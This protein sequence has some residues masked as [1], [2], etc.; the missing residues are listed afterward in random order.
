MRLIAHRG[1]MK[2]PNH[3]VENSKLQIM[4]ALEHGFDVEV[5]V[6]NIRG[7]WYLGHDMPMYQTDIVFLSEPRLWIHAKNLEALYELSKTKFNYFWHQQDDF[8]LTSHGY[9][10]TY[11]NKQLTNH[12]ICVMPNW[13]DGEIRSAK[14]AGCYGICSDY[15]ALIK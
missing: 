10:W 5:D 6:W 12:S 9:I 15:V 11:P 1:L 3:D 7:D 13:H 4:I 2:G 8:T 14:E